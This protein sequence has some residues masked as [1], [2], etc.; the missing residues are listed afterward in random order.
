MR[1][2]TQLLVVTVLFVLLAATVSSSTTD[3]YVNSSEPAFLH[4][5]GPQDDRTNNPVA[6]AI[7]AV[8]VGLVFYRGFKVYGGNTEQQ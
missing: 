8:V 5:I 2:C 6:A 4:D 3:Q 7:T 1:C